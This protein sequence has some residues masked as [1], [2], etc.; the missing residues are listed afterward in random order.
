[1]AFLFGE[2]GM[3]KRRM[4]DGWMMMVVVVVVCIYPRLRRA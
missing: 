3:V 1:M 4:R 2:R